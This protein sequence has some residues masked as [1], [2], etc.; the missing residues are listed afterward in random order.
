MT[1]KTRFLD[2]GMNDAGRSD[3]GASRRSNSF[4]VRTGW[5][6]LHSFDAAGAMPLVRLR[7]AASFVS[8][9]CRRRKTG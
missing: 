7:V 1:F 3:R 9:F 8:S 4:Q 2:V 6:I 5:G